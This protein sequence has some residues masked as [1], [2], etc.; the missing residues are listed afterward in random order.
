MFLHLAIPI[1]LGVYYW[2][3]WPYAKGIAKYAKDNN[4]GSPGS[5]DA[6][7]TILDEKKELM[8]AIKKC[9]PWEIFMEFFDVV[10]SV[11]KYLIVKYLPLP[12]YTNPFLWL[13]VFPF[14]MPAAIKLGHRYN[15]YGCIR[16]HARPNKNHICVVNQYLN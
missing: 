3:G 9:N 5:E 6:Y 8:D 4:N 12:V 7:Q 15:K 13:G 14:V 2:Y 11:I 16:N 10:Q 1:G